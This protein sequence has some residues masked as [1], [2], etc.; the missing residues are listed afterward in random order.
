MT[1][2]FWKLGAPSQNMNYC[3]EP[4]SM[5]CLYHKSTG[6]K[7]KVTT[8]NVNLYPEL[9]CGFDL[10]HTIVLR[11]VQPTKHQGSLYLIKDELWAFDCIL[12][13]GKGGLDCFVFLI[14]IFMF[15]QLKTFAIS[16]FH[17]AKYTTY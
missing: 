6:M 11:R 2:Y 4:N 8:H 7:L 12:G 15:K 14:S 16:N 9:R 17:A 1:P 5:P 13:S 10:R 3:Y